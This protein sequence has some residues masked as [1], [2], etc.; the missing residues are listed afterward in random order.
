VLEAKATIIL[1]PYN[2]GDFGLFVTN[3]TP[4]FGKK[5]RLRLRAVAESRLRGRLRLP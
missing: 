2:Q 4:L 3:A 1:C 5:D